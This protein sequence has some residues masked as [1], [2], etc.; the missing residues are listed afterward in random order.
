M[1]KQKCLE[2][3]SGTTEHN[4][5]NKSLLASLYLYK[6]LELYDAYENKLV[7]YLN[8]LILYSLSMPIEFLHDSRLGGSKEPKFLA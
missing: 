8:H 6:K 7:S 3:I 4:Q 5:F 1:Q 2:G